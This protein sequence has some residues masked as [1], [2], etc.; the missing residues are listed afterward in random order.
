MQLEK[1]T[2]H[3]QSV[4][5]QAL[6]AQD[7]AKI[8]VDGVEKELCKVK[9]ELLLLREERGK[10]ERAIDN[11]TVALRSLDV[12]VA[13]SKEALAVVERKAKCE[14]ERVK[15]EEDRIES[16]KQELSALEHRVRETQTLLSQTYDSMH[17]ERT[18]ALKE[19]EQFECMKLEAQQHLY[20]AQKVGNPPPQMVQLEVTNSQPQHAMADDGIGAEVV[21]QDA[22][23]ASALA[24]LGVFAS[25][26][27]SNHHGDA[28]F[29]RDSVERLRQQSNAVLSE[30]AQK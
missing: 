8:G 30:K 18:R 6:L 24:D 26:S 7:K 4:H 17:V 1:E 15:Q 19:L 2:R 23:A 3:A 9:D 11:A 14:G 16:K 5:H 28:A 22:V 13:E 25:I 20:T 12:Q 27:K 29:L 21:P 10:Q